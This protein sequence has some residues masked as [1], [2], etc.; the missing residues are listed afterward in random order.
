MMASGP[1]DFWLLPTVGA[2]GKGYHFELIQGTEAAE[3]V[4]TLQPKAPTTDPRATSV[5]ARLMASVLSE[6]ERGLQ[7]S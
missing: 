5:L 1:P 7:G 2:S 6:S 3:V 4:I